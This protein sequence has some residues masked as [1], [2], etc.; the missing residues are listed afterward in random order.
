MH[1]LGST[2]MPPGF[3]AGGLR[4]HGMAPLVS[5]LRARADRGHALITQN[6][7]FEAAVQFARRRHR[8][9][10]GVDPRGARAPSTRRC[11]ARR[12]AKPDHPVQSVRPRPLRH[13]RTSTISPASSSTTPTT[14]PRWPW[15]WRA[16]PAW[17]LDDTHKHHGRG[18]FIPASCQS[19]DAARRRL[20][21]TASQP[22]WARI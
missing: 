9:G 7:C 19:A 12:K 5:H 2:F 15:R 3:H 10:A 21:L 20:P 14:K 16:C 6:A 1:T 11:S 13:G 22:A 17:R 8:A 4:Y 18:V